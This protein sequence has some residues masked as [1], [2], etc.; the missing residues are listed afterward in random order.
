MTTPLLLPD[1]YSTALV[2]AEAFIRGELEVRAMV[3]SGTVVRGTGQANS[4]LDIV[5]VH[6]APWRQRLQRFFN[7]VPTEMFVNPPFQI[8]RQMEND[9]R[10]ARPVM[11][12]MLAT[13]HLL[14]DDPAGIGAALQ[15]EAH[16]NLAAGPVVDPEWLELRRYGIAG[17]FEDAI[18]LINID[19]ERAQ[20]FA[21]QAVIEAI[22]WW[23]P[24]HGHW[25]PRAKTL[26]SEFEGHVPDWSV[27][28]R[29]ALRAPNAANAI[30]EATPLI[31]HLLG[32]TGFFEWSGGRQYL[33]PQG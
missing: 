25:L 22:E 12:H 11:A 18:D 32:G 17:I 26:L 13:G 28:A 1:P 30:A 24:A 31:Q 29:R 33:S 14:Q 15:E 20:A 21:V 3:V 4:D 7:G 6:D 10:S 27:Q 9:A 16:A 8:R 2:A 19:P 23:F 5:V